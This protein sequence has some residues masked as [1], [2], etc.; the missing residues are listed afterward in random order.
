MSEDLRALVASIVATIKPKMTEANKA[1]WRLATSG[2]PEEARVA[3]DLETELRLLMS[4][5]DT[6]AKLK[7]AAAQPT[8]DTLLDRQLVSLYHGYLENQLDKDEIAAMVAKANELEQIFSN[9]RGT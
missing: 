8:G 4:D 6:F 7:A 2:K 5:R 3:A 9:F 1:Y